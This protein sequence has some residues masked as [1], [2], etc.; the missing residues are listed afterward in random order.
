MSEC[1][2]NSKTDS[3][4]HSHSISELAALLAQQ[5]NLVANHLLPNGKNIGKEWVVGS[6]NGEEGCSLSI[7]LSGEKAGIW[8]DFST[9]DEGG[10]L[11]EL[12]HKV[13]GISKGEALTEVRRFLGIQGLHYSLQKPVVVEKAEDKIASTNKPISIGYHRT[14]R[15]NLH[16]N[17]RAMAYLCG[18]KRGLSTKTIRHFGLGLSTPYQNSDGLITSDAVVAPMRSPTTGHFLNK[19]AY[20]CVPEVTQ[21]P[22][23]PNGWMKGEVQCYYSD[24]LNKQRNI[25]VCEGLKDVWRHW[26]A[27]SEA[28]FDD[29][30]LVSSTHGSAIPREWK[31]AEFWTKWDSVYLGQDN[32]DAG[33]KIA[34]RVAEL[35][36]KEARR[37]K[38]PQGF[39]KDWTDFWQN[40]GDVERFRTLITEAATVSGV[41]D[42]IDYGIVDGVQRIGQFSHNP[43]DINGAFVNGHLYYPAVTHVVK[44]D[45]ES[46]AIVELLETIVIRSDSTVHR[47]IYAPAPEGTPFNKRVLKL[48][49]GTVIEKEPRASATRTWDFDS[50]RTYLNGTA[51]SRLLKSLVDDILGFLRQ[52]IWLPH[53]EDYVVLALAVP[54]TYVQAVFESVPLLLLNGPAGS[55]KSQ[56]GNTMAR[57]C[58]N[59]IV[60]GQVSAATAARMIDETR[61]FVVLDDVESIAAKA[62]K[63]IQV[64]ELVQA[65]KVSYNKHTAVKYWT[66]VKT[67]KTERLDFFGVKLLNNTLG[68]DAILGTRMIRIQTRKMPDGVISNIRDFGADDLL[69]L[70]K[71]RNEL[72]VWAFENVQMVERIYREVFQNKTDRHSEISAPLR[73]VSKIVGDSEIARQ[74]EFSLGRQEI[75]KRNEN[76][77]PVETLKEAVRNLIMQGFSTVTLTHLRLEIRVLLDPN[78]G[79]SNTTEIPEWD[80]P[81]WIGRQ[82]RSNDLVADVDL[83]RKRVHGKNLRLVRFSDWMLDGIRTETDENGLRIDQPP[84]KN[85]EDFCQG[86]QSCAYRLAGCELQIIRQFDDAK[87]AR[88][89]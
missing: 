16:S 69:R 29:I 76:D 18:E 71:L 87:A 82:L 40:G 10:D 60:I 49:D 89:H 30:L 19:S 65:L 81:E 46:G 23:D 70:R 2:I 9:A 51:P 56:T 14:L 36:G 20:I 13:R 27:L 52:S 48:T 59:G 58:S 5:A 67:M 79:M 54:V 47:A 31:T 6:I 28:G 8:K 84:S 37:I 88:A 43:I 7:C 32:D 42:K 21:N 4:A 26:Q 35:I 22:V 74:L 66:D 45:E 38:V 73:T 72:H 63:D 3:Y 25:F 62:G 50:I 12:W 61:G 55:G 85:V 75:Q 17:S 53:E 34:E 78:Y 24:A 39:G 68:A 41:S 83:G 80:R 33:N 1:K 64:N 77:D 44:K 11:V 86:C 57:L 15:T